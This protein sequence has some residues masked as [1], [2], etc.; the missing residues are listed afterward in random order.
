MTGSPSCLC[1][2][3]LRFDTK[4]EYKTV[5]SERLGR[6]ETYQEQYVFVYR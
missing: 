6:S 4:Y 2:F 5:A 3:T 1:C